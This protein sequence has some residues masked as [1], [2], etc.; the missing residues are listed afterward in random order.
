[1]FKKLFTVALLS[2]L[3]L[4]AVANPAQDTIGTVSQETRQ[5][6]ALPTSNVVVVSQD[7]GGSIFEYIENYVKYRD[8]NNQ[9][10]I[11]DFCLSACTLVLSIIPKENVCV[12]P[13]AILGF[14][15]A[16]NAYTGEFAE[17]A[18][19]LIWH[20]YPHEVQDYLRDRGWDGDGNKPHPNFLYV[21][22]SYFYPVCKDLEKAI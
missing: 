3:P 8:Q 10:V 4:G 20:S 19:R 7:Y 11:K 13:K 16:Y 17:E 1:M 5:A 12:S 14:H 6:V 2:L 21:K 18:T 9:I 15:S 22:A